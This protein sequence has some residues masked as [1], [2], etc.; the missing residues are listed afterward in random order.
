[1]EEELIDAV[2]RAFVAARGSSVFV[3]AAEYHEIVAA[4]VARGAGRRIQE[5]LPEELP[6]RGQRPRDAAEVARLAQEDQAFWTRSEAHERRHAAL[7]GERERLVEALLDMA[8]SEQ[9]LLQREAFRSLPGLCPRGLEEEWAP[10]LFA[11]LDQRDSRALRE[12]ALMTLRSLTG[13]RLPASG[14]AWRAWWEEGRQGETT[15]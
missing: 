11:A 4:G 8:G 9:A 2:A 3:P 12:T 7:E 10:L 13:E 5:R 6:S 1:V 15:E 14:V